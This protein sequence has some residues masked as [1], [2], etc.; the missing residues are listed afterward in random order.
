MGRLITKGTEMLYSLTQKE[1]DKLKRVMRALYD[2][3]QSEQGDAI[4]EIMSKLGRI[5]TDKIK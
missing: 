5:P 2:S 4:F 1:F 3:D